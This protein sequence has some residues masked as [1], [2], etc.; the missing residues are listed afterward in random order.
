[1]GTEFLSLG[2]IFAAQ[3]REEHH[4]TNDP[5]EDG[6]AKMFRAAA[7]GG[8]DDK[9]VEVVEAPAP[10]K[11]QK[12]RRRAAADRVDLLLIEA[13]IRGPCCHSRGR[14]LLRIRNGN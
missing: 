10:P 8:E 14:A 13:T 6:L 9:A 3:E 2:S 11:W 12:S 1:M 5:K 4:K 7:T